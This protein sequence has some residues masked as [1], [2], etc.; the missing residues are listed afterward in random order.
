MNV[1]NVRLN[2][3]PE[4]AFKGECVNSTCLGVLMLSLNHV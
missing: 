3:L 4:V 1:K 2:I